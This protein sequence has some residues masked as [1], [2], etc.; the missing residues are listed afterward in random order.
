M[1]P[2]RPLIDAFVLF[3]ETGDDFRSRMTQ[4]L[5]IKAR[6]D[7]KEYYLDVVIRHYVRAALDYISG[8]SD[9]FP[10]VEKFFMEDSE[11]KFGGEGE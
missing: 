11:F 3:V 6:F 5:Q 1:E 4:V 10:V 7:D 2:F 9:N 8:Q